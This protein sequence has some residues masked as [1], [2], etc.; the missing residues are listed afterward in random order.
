MQLKAYKAEISE[1]II[2]FQKYTKLAVF[3]DVALAINNNIMMHTADIKDV[4]SLIE[5]QSINL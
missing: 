1:I 4:S 3:N 5:Q 2:E